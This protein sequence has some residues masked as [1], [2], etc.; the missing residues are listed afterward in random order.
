M[1]VLSTVGSSPLPGGVYEC[2][3]GVG[4]EYVVGVKC[5]CGC[6]MWNV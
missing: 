5:R 1:R 3:G 6:G 4:G 2:N